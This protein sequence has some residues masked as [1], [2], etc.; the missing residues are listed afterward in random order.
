MALNPERTTASGRPQDYQAKTIIAHKVAFLPSPCCSA[1]DR[2]LLR[3]FLST[4]SQ[5][6]TRS[7][8][9]SI[10]EGSL[11]KMV[12]EREKS[13]RAKREQA[14]SA[15]HWQRRLPQVS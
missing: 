10:R 14:L 4:C 13:E 7:K 8:D 5:G 1:P 3:V 2:K 12:K 11:D 6:T 15:A 9:S